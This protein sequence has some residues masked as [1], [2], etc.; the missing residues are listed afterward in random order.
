MPHGTEG[1]ERPSRLVGLA[2]AVAGLGLCTGLAALGLTGTVPGG[3]A[4]GTTRP[5]ASAA[6]AAATGSA[7]AEP[8]APPP[9]LVATGP[10]ALIADDIAL[11]R[12]EDPGW[13]GTNYDVSPCPGQPATY[14]ALSTVNDLRVIHSLARDPRRVR[15]LA[16]TADEGA[17]ADL[18][19]QLA[20]PF[21]SCR[22]R[23]AEAGTRSAAPVEGDQWQEG[24]M[25]A[26]SLS[27]EDG[28]APV[29]GYLV[30]ARAGRAVVAQTVVGASAPVTDGV[31]V[32]QGLA[33]ELQDFLDTMADRVCRY[34]STGCHTPL[35]PRYEPPAG[36]VA[37]PDGVFQ[38]PDGSVV[39]ADGTLLIPAPG[40]DPDGHPPVG[41]SRPTSS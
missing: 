1:P 41:S 27:G 20:H 28:H 39:A 3:S 24:T 5:P 8:T 36:S 9:R 11:P 26:V 18:V 10:L 38:L 13:S 29:N 40:L 2:A 30:V 34:R 4:A 12:E 33:D 14:P 35:P 25:L 32:H 6:T 15:L 23:G 16:V 21:E 31:A 19:R 7:D 17:A 22:L 37:L